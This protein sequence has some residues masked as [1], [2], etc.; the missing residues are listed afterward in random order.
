MEH[1]SMKP[2]QTQNSN[3]SLPFEL[4]EKVY[5]HLL[6]TGFVVGFETYS[7][8]KA[9][10][11]HRLKRVFKSPPDIPYL[12]GISLYVLRKRFRTLRQ[13]SREVREEAI[14]VLFF[15]NA[16]CMNITLYGSQSIWKKDTYQNYSF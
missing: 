7:K 16:I 8:E 11:H 10:A 3:I 6:K 2:H 4:R 13:V 15:H 14:R 12:K 5:I 9:S 1:L